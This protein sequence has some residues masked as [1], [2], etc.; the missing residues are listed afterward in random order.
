MGCWFEDNIQR[1]VGNG[2]DSFFRK[3]PWLGEIP[4]SVRFPRLFEM[5]VN[6]WMMVA[7]MFSLGWGEGGEGR[8][9]FG[10]EVCW[11]RMSW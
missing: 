2:V 9:G 4:L 10:G 6:S 8:L 11:R 3:N 7:D 5:S 1:K